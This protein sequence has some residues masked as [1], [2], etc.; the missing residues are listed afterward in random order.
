[1][2]ESTMPESTLPK[3]TPSKPTPSKLTL[4]KL[5]ALLSCV[6]LALAIAPLVA[7]EPGTSAAVAAAADRE[8]RVVTYNIRY[9]SAT[10][11]LDRWELRGPR[12]IAT[13]DGL[14]GDLV[15]LQE[16]EAFQVR[17][18]LTALPRYAALGVHRD[19]G[20]T[21]G[22]SCTILY[23]RARFAVAESATFW[24]SET[25]ERVAS[26]SW[27]AAL[28]RICTWARFVE[29]DGGRACYVF[30]VHLDHRGQ[31]SRVASTRLVRERMRAVV[32]R[33][34]FEAPAVLLGDFNAGE[35]NPAFTSL[36]AQAPEDPLQLVD[37]YRAIHPSDLAGTFNG[38]D[39]E[40]DGGSRKIDHLLVTRGLAVRGAGIDRRLIDGRQPSDHFAVWASLA[41]D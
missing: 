3:P 6:A 35:D 13:I 22:E 33:V 15:A 8:L 25:P 36:F 27:D 41:W 1:M 28:P 11:G 32:T 37:S 26:K 39:P 4:P 14:A 12:L 29:L 9:G 18:L 23:D 40:S 38:F 10:D 24:L 21:R 17:E 5:T 31:D 19:D 20:R 30:N 16:A 7:Q 34:G 2:L